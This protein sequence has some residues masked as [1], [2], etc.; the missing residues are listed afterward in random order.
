MK[1]ILV[2]LAVVYTYFAPTM[3]L[4]QQ[5]LDEENISKANQTLTKNHNCKEAIMY[6]NFVSDSGKTTPAY[7]LGMAK[8]YDCFSDNAKSLD[9][10][11]R[12]LAINP[13]DESARKRANEL[14]DGKTEVAKVGKQEMQAK[15]VYK[16]VKSG[17]NEKN[18][19][20]FAKKYFAF[21]LTMDNFTGGDK[22]AF[23][24]SYNFFNNEGYSFS[25]QH[26]LFEFISQIGY[27]TNANN[28]WFGSVFNVPASA[29]TNTPSSISC[30]IELS[31]ASIVY[32]T[33]KM[34]ISVGPTLGFYA[35][36][37][38]SLDFNIPMS[39]I[40]SSQVYFSP[41]LG[42]KTT[43][44]LNKHLYFA[45]EY[46]ILKSSDYQNTEDFAGTSTPTNMNAIRLT[47]GLRGFGF[48]GHYGH[49]HP[50]Y[51]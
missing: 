42:I 33:P 39:N 5:G 23:K 14:K 41:S 6:L 25:K 13:N 29:I 8:A 30:S 38:P 46:V 20:V 21:G 27:I 36:F 17:K 12:Y 44:L 22:S 34:G 43:M 11:N 7:L 32:N 48:P 24:Q 15:T 28:N 3:V 51:F 35:F 45:L 9:Y 26:M 47:A 2:I 4:A 49:S 37:L 50:S 31:L 10:Y 16:A 18:K 40:Y 19:R 1:K